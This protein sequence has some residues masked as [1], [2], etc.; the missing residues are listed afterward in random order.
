MAVGLRAAMLF[1]P[2]SFPHDFLPT[3]AIAGDRPYRPSATIRA[4]SRTTA[5]ARRVSSISRLSRKRNCE[6]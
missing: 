1:Q 4:D 2:V 5:S 6:K 3:V